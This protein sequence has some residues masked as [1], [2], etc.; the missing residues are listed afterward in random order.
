[1]TRENPEPDTTAEQQPADASR[2]GDDV[3]EAVNRAAS[4]KAGGGVQTPPEQAKP[5]AAPVEQA[6]GDEA[7]TQGQVVDG[8]GEQSTPPDNPSPAA[9]GSGG[10]QSIVG[11]RVSDRESAGE[12]PPGEPP[13]SDRDAS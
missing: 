8:P 9:A 3:I 12:G 7:M 13:F 6:R 2:S 1:M 11:G 5:H 10:A 4:G